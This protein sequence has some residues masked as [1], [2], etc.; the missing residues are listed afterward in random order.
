MPI[1]ALLRRD[2]EIVK[3]ALTDSYVT[4]LQT[5]LTPCSEEYSTTLEGR[6]ACPPYFLLCITFAYASIDS[7]I[8]NKREH[9][10]MFSHP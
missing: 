3:Y 4:S 7:V 2:S 1:E 10:L 8:H 6:K 5:I 9:L